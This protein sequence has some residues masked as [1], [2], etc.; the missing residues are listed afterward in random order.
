ML[1]RLAML[2]FFVVLT[3]C[4]DDGPSVARPDQLALQIVRGDR[5][6]ARVADAPA[7]QGVAGYSPAATVP[8]NILP[9]PLV[10]R[11]VIDG[12][13]PSAALS[14]GDPLGPSFA[15]L[16]QGT[17][18]TFRVIQPDDPKGRHCGTSFL[19]AGVPDDSGYVTTFWERGTLAGE[20]RMEV[21]LVVD[22]MPRID[23]V[24]VATFEPGPPT[25]FSFTAGYRGDPVVIAQGDSLNLMSLVR[26]GS[27]IHG[28]DTSTDDLIATYSPE[29]AWVIPTFLYQGGA[30]VPGCYRDEDQLLE[31]GSGVGWVVGGAPAPRESAC[32]SDYLRSLDPE[33]AVRVTIPEIGTSAYVY[34]RISG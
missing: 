34:V 4:G 17:A 15:V 7:S 33:Y 26:A 20:C 5:Q 2:A 12:Q 16:P 29:W 11:I 21:R 25:S 31:N 13:P 18:V 10:A 9:E 23:T 22:Q 28:N 6:V 27:D 1:R 19:D 32:T 8:D 30:I 14:P 3:A 24:F